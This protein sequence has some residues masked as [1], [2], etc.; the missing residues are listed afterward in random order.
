MWIFPCS[1][2]TNRSLDLQDEERSEETSEPDQ[3]GRKRCE[4]AKFLGGFRLW[5]WVGK[6][7]LHFLAVTWNPKQPPV[8]CPLPGP[9]GSH[10][11]ASVTALNPPG[12]WSQQPQQWWFCPF[13]FNR[14][15]IPPLGCSQT[16]DWAYWLHKITLMLRFLQ[17]SN[18]KFHGK[19][20][21]PKTLHFLNSS[22]GK[23]CFQYIF[24]KSFLRTGVPWTYCFVFICSFLL[25]HFTKWMVFW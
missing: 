25:F 13:P 1:N 16:Q 23:Y 21:N 18:R 9:A 5:R 12:L 4:N 19:F 17:L 14:G 8:S 3:R 6:Q 22:G 10:P 11:K 2:T 24:F 7:G 15:N 20:W